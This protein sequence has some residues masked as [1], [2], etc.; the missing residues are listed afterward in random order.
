MRTLIA[1]VLRLSGAAVFAALASGAS[2]QTVEWRAG[3]LGGGWYTIVS[4]ASKL[5]EDKN[6]G[7]SVKAVPGAGAANPTSVQ[8]GQAQLG[9]S[10]D[11]FAKMARDGVG[12]YEGRPK[13]DKLMMIGQ[14]M[15]D[16]PYHFIRAKGQTMEIEDLFKNGRN[17]RFGGGKAG[18]TDEIALRW[19]M[20]HYGQSYDS[21]RARGWR[22]I[23]ADYNE[24]ASGFKDGQIDYVFFAQGL[25]GASVVDMATSREGE[26]LQMP[27]GLL[28]GIKEKHG[29][30]AGVIPAGTYP[31][32]QARDVKVLNMQTTLI[33]SSDAPEDLVYKVTK[34]L[35]D[36]EADLP[37]IH[38]SLKDFKCATAIAERPVPVHPG[39]MRYF[40][41]RGIATN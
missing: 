21:L 11:I 25:P 23:L 10:I 36:N 32:F 22:F 37:K 39:A 7:M 15:G 35:C 38:A 12:V 31:R 27:D 1:N 4:G 19:V 13:H 8:S 41:E 28:A 20:A 33:T 2:A 17:I 16:T 9:M 40:R 5:L 26:L 14:S 18:A 6:P 30:G 3:A 34:T 24:L 29:M